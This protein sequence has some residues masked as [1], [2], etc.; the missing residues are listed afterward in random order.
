[1]RRGDRRGRTMA[2]GLT[3]LLVTSGA[4]V[5]GWSAA[6]P[7]GPVHTA[8]AYRPAGI[9]HGRGMSQFG[10]M[11]QA[12]AGA[13]ADHI[14]LSYY[15]GATLA[16]V[17]R[18][19]VRV[20]L[21]SDDGEPLDVYSDTG[22]LV[23][24]R[25]VVAGQAAH[26]TPTPGGGAD[27]V[28]S[29]D[30][31]G[32]TL[33]RGHI[34]DPWAYPLDPGSN[35]PA[36]E[37]LRICGAGTYRGALGVAL[38]G[39]AAR[40]INEVDV[41]DYLLGV[42]PAE[43]QANWA[44]RGGNEAL[45]AQAI[46]ARSYA[47]AE[48][49][50]PYAQTCDTTDCQEY[51]GTER[52]DDR[53]AAAVRSTVGQVLLRTGRILRTEYSSAPDGGQPIDITTLDL[54]PA[55]QQLAAV[56][57]PN[58]APIPRPQTVIDAKYAETG[59]NSGP[60]GS[61]EGPELP[62]PGNLGTYRQFH[63]GVIVATAALGVQVIDLGAL[64]ALLHPVPRP[65]DHPLHD[66]TPAPG[67]AATPTPSPTPMAPVPATA[68][69]AN[70]APAVAASAPGTSGAENA[71]AAAGWSSVEAPVRRPEAASAGAGVAPHAGATPR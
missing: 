47:L 2:A 6:T 14:L 15:P 29:I 38:E 52:E 13:S 63:N 37:H 31:D 64:N 19:P 26:L 46:A 58:I 42:V 30:C 55:P 36:A 61:P 8:D 70:P 68:P 27:V 10:A 57:H 25:R 20:R 3:T 16:A 35:R 21:T 40:T 18:T 5:V 50:Y 54:G 51:P 43:M 45:R 65:A 11:E 60:L 28:V 53:A 12:A 67:T 41:E 32:D 56:P 62:L 1:M 49:R 7:A 48:H 69:D 44:D 4:A 59:G 66:A 9:G 23:G 17:P 24:G 33:W 71:G 22:L 34:D 39:D